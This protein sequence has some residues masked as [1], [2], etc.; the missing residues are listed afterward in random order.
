MPLRGYN[1]TMKYR[2]RIPM[3]S[4][5]VA[6]L[7]LSGTILVVNGLISASETIF[8]SGSISYPVVPS[9]HTSGTGLYDSN[10]N[11]ARLYLT[12]VHDGQ[13][14]HMSQSEI[15]HIASLGFKGLRFFIYWGQVQ[16][17]PTTINQAYFSSGSGEPGSN[18]IDN[19]VNWARDAGLYVM[20]CPCWTSYWVPPAWAI[21]SSGLSNGDGGPSI[22]VDMLNNPT[23]QTGIE[24]LYGWIASRYASYS[25]VVFES[26][27][28]LSSLSRPCSTA[29]RQLWA[30]FN[31]LWVSAIEAKEGGN[32]HIKVIQ[33]IYDGSWANYCLYSP[34]LSG[35]HANVILAT[36]SY[37]L[38]DS[39]ASTATPIAT[40]WS[41]FIHGIGYPWMDTEYSHYLGGGL[42]GLQQ[43]TNLLVNGG[44]VGW[45]YFDYEPSSNS[46]SGCN[47]NNPTNAPSI[48]SI[49]KPYMNV[50]TW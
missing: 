47:V 38:A 35:S 1:Q 7:L 19:I 44:S 18:A 8:F 15:Q 25:N 26:F 12:V 50:Y 20:L 48:L 9:L 22:K 24:Y 10:N 43:A 37:P 31:N 42:A 45:G 49:L 5:V 13:G 46:N 16:P 29:E 3:H 2:N 40:A 41:N 6:L 32:S 23:I 33:L 27:N 28:E 34:I 30:N 21:G 14:Y 39:P 17:S 4:I 36:H 11:P